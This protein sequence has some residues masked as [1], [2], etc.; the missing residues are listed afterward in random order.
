M[1]WRSPCLPAPNLHSTHEH[2]DR[3]IVRIVVHYQKNIFPTT[4]RTARHTPVNT[5]ARDDGDD[6]LRNWVYSITITFPSFLE[7]VMSLFMNFP[8]PKTKITQTTKPT[9]FY[10]GARVLMIELA[11]S[12]W[13]Y[14]VVGRMMM[15]MMMVGI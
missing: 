11:L 10:F 14:H 3:C 1:E 6:E 13:V 4:T 2:R 15:M 9:T 5:L 7:F 12:V 8:T